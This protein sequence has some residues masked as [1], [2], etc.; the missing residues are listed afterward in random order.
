MIVWFKLDSAAVVTKGDAIKL[1]GQTVGTVTSGSYSPTLGRG[2]AMGYVEPP[3]VIQGLAFDLGPES[4]TERASLSVMP[5]YDPGDVRTT[6]R[7]AR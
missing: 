6:G 1:D 3:H 5:L 7:F 2:V 4:Q